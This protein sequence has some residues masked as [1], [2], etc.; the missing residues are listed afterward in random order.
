MSK[1]EYDNGLPPRAVP[2]PTQPE[3]H[4]GEREF[5]RLQAKV[6]YLSKKL[7]EVE[8]EENDR[9]SSLETRLVEW[10]RRYSYGKGIV[11]GVIIICG[12]FGI[13]VVDTVKEIINHVFFVNEHGP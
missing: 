3:A 4:V 6:E 2:D 9:L 1:D 5:V 13:F 11:G 10:D 7:R 8:E 12:I